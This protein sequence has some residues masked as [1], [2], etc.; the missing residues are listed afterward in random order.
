MG[1][2]IASSPPAGR[3]AAERTASLM[4]RQGAVA[5]LVFSALAVSM[6]AR[7]IEFGPFTLT[8]FIKN[9]FV[10]ANRQCQACQ[11]E[12]GE[13]KERA[14]ADP[15]VSAAPFE[16][17][18]TQ[19]VLFQ[20]WLGANF[21]L[22]RGYRLSGLLS[23]RRRDGDNDIP[24]F[25]Y[26][27]NVALSHEEYGRLAFGAMP[28]RSWSVA[29]YP[30]GSNIGQAEPWASS[31]AGYGLLT[32]ALRYTSRTFD[33][34]EG[35]LV[36]EITHDRGDTGFRINKPRFLEFYGQYVKGDLVVDAIVQDTR[37]GT[38]SS[39]GHGPF[40][41]LT[42]FAAD[43]PLLS[44]SSQSI[45]MLMARYQVDARWEVSGGVRRNR[46]SGADAVVT[47]TDPSTGFDIWNNMFNVN[48]GP[49][50]V[51]VNPEGFP[52]RSIDFMAGARY[53]VG[54]WTWSAGMTYLGKAS[55]DNPSERGQSNTAWIGS[56]GLSHDFGQGLQAYVLAGA[57][58]YGRL[59]LSP[60]S[61]PGNAAFSGVDSRAHR[62]GNWMGLGV[63]YTF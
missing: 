27:R 49:T 6:P 44:P 63:L 37:N 38:P 52:A 50:A 14:W 35:D 57:V 7:A 4:G 3:R 23:Q 20:P 58:R 22:G 43:D 47:R 29:D 28:T 2:S 19:T 54:P 60:L 25:L 51:G 1:H 15:L 31:G 55:T 33:V 10:R 39:W 59:G 13:G 48:W 61:M 21:D 40:T 62:S 26:E 8:G 17:R 45:A 46:W 56:L 18:T 30:Y 34:A 12:V 16:T 36:L 53:R 24:G 32:K 11:V 9:E 41:G 42:P 5:M